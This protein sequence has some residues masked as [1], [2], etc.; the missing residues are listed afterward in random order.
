MTRHKNTGMPMGSMKKAGGGKV[1]TS[2][3]T[4]RKLATE[5]GGMKKGGKPKASGLAVMIAIGSPMKGMKKPVKKA[6]GGG[7]ES[8][9]P[10]PDGPSTGSAPSGKPAFDNSNQMDM[11][12]A[13]RG[14]LI[15]PSGLGSASAGKEAAMARMKAAQEARSD[16]RQLIKS[17]SRSTGG[18][19]I[20][21][22]PI[23]IPNSGGTGLPSS[24]TKPYQRPENWFIPGKPGEGGFSGGLSREYMDASQKRNAEYEA[25][26]ASRK[27]TDA[28]KPAS[29]IPAPTD[30]M[31]LISQPMAAPRP[32]AKGGVVKKAQGGAGKVRKGMMTPEGKIIDAMN[33]IRGK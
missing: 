29:N 8:M 2:A 33:K 31:K 21:G 16:K 12:N 20:G 24:P 5:M 28:N 4:A 3:D 7:M 17:V 18:G 27:Y 9:I 32:I 26:L 1:Q 10:A 30:H 22:M 11:Y 25:R 15:M 13:T 23:S 19:S 6:M 14:N